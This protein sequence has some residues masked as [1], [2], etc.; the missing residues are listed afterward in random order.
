[1]LQVLGGVVGIKS[2]L[3]VTHTQRECF[4]QTILVRGSTPNCHNDRLLP[5][6]T[7]G[8]AGSG[9]AQR[10]MIGCLVHYGRSYQRVADRVS[11]SLPTDIRKLSKDSF[12]EIARAVPSAKCKS[13]V[14]KV[15][16]VL[17]G[18]ASLSDIKENCSKFI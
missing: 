15:F 5:T 8:S 2:R 11:A 10:L 16:T 7:A 9:V 12:C 6:L 17:K 3:Y 14:L 1:M 4:K 13:D 18:N